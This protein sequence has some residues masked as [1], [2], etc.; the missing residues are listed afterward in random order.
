MFGKLV[1]L[2]LYV[3]VWFFCKNDV[4]LVVEFI[5][6][7]FLDFVFFMLL[8]CCD[9]VDDIYLFLVF[10]L[11]NLGNFVVWLVLRILGLKYLVFKRN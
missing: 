6:I 10:K 1:C 3:L 8:L 7:N 9:G 11:G 2:F 5:F 4:K